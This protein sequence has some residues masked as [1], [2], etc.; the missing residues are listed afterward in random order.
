MFRKV[1]EPIS[2]QVRM[3]IQVH[4]SNNWTLYVLGSSCHMIIPKKC[5][6]GNSTWSGMSQK[7]QQDLR[8][9]CSQDEQCRSSKRQAPTAP[10]T[11]PSSTWA[12]TGLSWWESGSGATSGKLCRSAIPPISPVP[13]THSQAPAPRGQAETQETCGL[14]SHKLLS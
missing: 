10:A 3:K 8:D 2:G 5:H 11:W 6:Q 12:R 13:R 9:R 7:W 1:T 4:S 14:E